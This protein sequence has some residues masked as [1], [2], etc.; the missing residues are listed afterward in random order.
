MG[1]KMYSWEE[2]IETINQEANFQKSLLYFGTH[3]DYSDNVILMQ[4]TGLT[5]KNGKEIYE[6]D[7]MRIPMTVGYATMVWEEEQ[8]G[9]FAQII[10]GEEIL[11]ARIDYA[12][13]RGIEVIGNIYE[14]R[15]LLKL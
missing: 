4:F 7:I 11:S 6:G 14:N 2:I 10:E 12:N 8:A 1:N 15:E 5:D 9:F 3:S 13:E